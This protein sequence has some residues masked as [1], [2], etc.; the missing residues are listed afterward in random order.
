MNVTATAKSELLDFIR[1]ERERWETLLDQI[2]IAHMTAWRDAEIARLEA[3]SCS[4][5]PAAPPWPP[6][7][8]VDQINAWIYQHNRDRSLGDVLRD[9]R[10]S[11]DRLEAAVRAVTEADL[12][13]PN[14]F[15]WMDGKPIG[16]AVVHD[17]LAYFPEEHETALR[18]WLA[19]SS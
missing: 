7:D 3:A 2:G 1:H 9:S 8:D 12:F 18:D 4:G 16:P 14:R 10:A 11:F 5:T 15:P 17:A 13:A 19:R 6:S